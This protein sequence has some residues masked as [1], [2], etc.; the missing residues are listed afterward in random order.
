MHIRQLTIRNIRSIPEFDLSLKEGECPGWHVLLG[1][2]GSGK[3][4]LVRALRPF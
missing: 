2:N 3:S 1:E 4:T